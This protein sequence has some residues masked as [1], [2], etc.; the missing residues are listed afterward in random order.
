MRQCVVMA[1]SLLLVGTV[2]VRGQHPEHPHG[3]PHDRASHPPM[4]PEL[5]ALIHGLLGTWTGTATSPDGSSTS[6]TL[7]ATN[8]K[9]GT[10]TLKPPASASKD[11]GAARDV[12]FD[13]HSLRW[14]QMLSGVS[15]KASATVAAATEQ[16]VG[17]MKG[18][19]AC[20]DR[21]MAFALEKT[22][23]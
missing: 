9:Q 5:H 23:N 3:Q 20:P 6:L 4:D 15:C 13:G 10:L 16:T 2:P 17:T 8:D 21:E 14:T 12:V 1:V 22:K 7:A 19:M 18:T 11:V